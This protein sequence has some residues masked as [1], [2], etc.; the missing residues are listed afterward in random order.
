MI[1]YEDLSIGTEVV[2]LNENGWAG[3]KKGGVY[4]V[5]E[6]WDCGISLDGGEP[7]YTVSSEF[8][9]DFDL[10]VDNSH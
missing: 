1:K 4:T 7:S 6:L 2:C 5:A 10:V 8:F 9:E 3:F